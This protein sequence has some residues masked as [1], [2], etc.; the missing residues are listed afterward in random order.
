MPCG[1][2][3]GN[4][5]TF[6]LFGTELEIFER[7]NRRNKKIGCV[8]PPSYGIFLLGPV[9]QR[10]GRAIW[11]CF[12]ILHVFFLLVSFRFVVVF[13]NILCVVFPLEQVFFGIEP[14]TLSREEV[15]VGR[16]PL[17][18]FHQSDSCRR[19]WAQPTKASPS[20]A[21]GSYRE[22]EWA[23]NKISLAERLVN[24]A[25]YLFL[26]PFKNRKETS[27]LR[28]RA[29]VAWEMFFFLEGMK[30][31]LEERERVMSSLSAPV[32]RPLGKWPFFSS[33]C[34]VCVFSSSAAS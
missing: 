24:K 21:P 4:I 9:S 10:S 3:K 18:M 26:S 25:S 11:R 27:S 1:K 33:L 12:F 31:N 34:R 13:F 14:D 29:A 23:G 6:F 2:K 16:D 17:F 7:A 8:R 20:V 19:L 30:I 28:A 5:F 22:V 15:V 32:S